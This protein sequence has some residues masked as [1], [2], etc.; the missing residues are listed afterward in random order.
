MKGTAPSTVIVRRDN[1]LLARYPLSGDLSFQVQ[2]AEGPLSICISNKRVAVI[3][4]TCK[5]QVCVHT[6]Y[7]EHPHQQIICVPNH[8]IV[9]IVSPPA[10][11][12]IDAINH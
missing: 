5:N 4:A 1:T 12:T 9:E 10:A 6:G 3:Q 11:G 8:I 7:I 2:G